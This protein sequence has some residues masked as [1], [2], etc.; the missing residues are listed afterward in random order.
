VIRTDFLVIGSGIAGLTYALEASVL[1]DVLIVTKDEPLTANTNYA[2]GG[3]ASVFGSS[4]SLDSHIADTLRTG[5]GL[6]DDE[7]VRMVIQDGPETILHLERLG[8]HFDR[9]DAQFDLGQEGGHS[10]R[11]I[12]HAKDRTGAEILNALMDRVKENKHIQILSQHAAVD[13]IAAL[14]NSGKK[15]VL[16]AHVFSKRTHQV[17]SIG[18]RVTMLA[19]GGAG[20][21]YLYTSNPDVATGDGVAMSY[22]CGARI[23]N[24][25]FFQFHPT[26][27]HHPQ[28]KSFLLTE[29]LRGEGAKLLTPEGRPFM[30]DFHP[31][32][33]L[34]SRDIVARAIDSQM[35][36]SG[37]DYMLLDISFKDSSYLKERFPHV[38]E[39]TKKF[40]FDIT[41]GPIPVVP[42]A[43]Y[44]CGG[45]I[46]DKHG[47]TDLFGLYAAGEVACTRF[48]GANRLA[49]NSLLESAVF[50]KRAAMHTA[51]NLDN[52]PK[53][54][55]V[56]PWDYMD[57]VESAEEV[58]VSHTWEEV[59][60][61]MWNLV[62][63]VRS[64]TRL[65]RAQ[66]RIK[67][68]KEEI[69]EYYWRYRLTADL[70]ELRNI[71]DVAELTIF[72]ASSRKESRGL[73]YNIDHLRQDDINWKKDT[74]VGLSPQNAA[75]AVQN[76]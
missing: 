50:A 33:E 9:T 40:G 53:V 60:R 64:D 12:L 3:I 34:A 14:D 74:I 4:D 65:E 7:I 71:I 69:R 56:V 18:A 30:L 63:I 68:L 44:S 10:E 41:T 58:I 29:A 45:V 39:T 13:L 21:A 72:C 35:K 52:Y 57:T 38:Y 22:R 55:R 67:F 37:A 6:S 66:K 75:K 31:D 15:R 43:H 47:Q 51:L 5:C 70:I 59:R 32:G 2:Q 26:C 49:S 42:A 28:A 1:G 25:E 17:L 11:R 20:K 23:A 54:T 24:M 61:L 16:G 19:T 27:L 76:S 62:G 73:H 46:T 8:A 48:H 36:K